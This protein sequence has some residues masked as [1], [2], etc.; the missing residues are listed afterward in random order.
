MDVPAFLEQLKSAPWYRQQ[1][2]HVEMIPPRGANLGSLNDPL[3]PALQSILEG[4]EMW[5][6]YLHQTDAI[7]GLRSGQNVVVAT[8][9]ASGK[10]LCYHLPVI[11]TIL[12]DR[13]A[14]ALYIYPSKALAQDQL[15]S[16]KDLGEG[17]PVQAAIFDGDTPGQVRAGIKRSAQI[18]L[19]NPDMLHLGI[20]PN[21][22]TWSRL[23]RSLRYVVLD[24]A[25]IYRGVFGSHM[26]NVVRRLR[27]LCTEYGSSPQFILCSA[28]IANPGE[29]AQQLTGLPFLVVDED[30]APYGGK[31]FAFWNPPLL[32][33]NPAFGSA[34]GESLG[35]PAAGVKF[36]GSLKPA[37]RSANTEAASLL[38][39]LVS[40]D[41]RTL[42]F[43]RTR[44]VAELVYMYARDQLNE[45]Q[46]PL[47]NRISPYRASYMAD[48]RR[49]IEKAL[50][51]GE[52]TGVAATNALE[53]GI[54]VR[55][56]D[57]TV[58]T[59]Y[60]GS[61][62][63]TWQQS[64][65]SGRRGEESLSVFIARDNPLDQYFMNHPQTFFGRPVERALLAPDNP[66]IMQPHLL[67]A[68]YESPLSGHDS[69]LFGPN[70]IEYL[71]GLL[72]RGFL[73]YAQGKWHIDPSV[74]Y[75]AEMV[76][77]RSTSPHNYVVVQGESGV[78]LETVEEASAMLQLH[79]GAVYLHRGESYLVEHLDLDSRTATVGPND[80]TYYTQA[81]DITD[82]TVS[83][84]RASKVTGGVGVWLGDVEVVNQ[85]IGFKKRLPMTEE[86]VGDEPLDLPPRRFN[87]V[88][89]W[90]DVPQGITDRC[91]GARLDLAGGLHATEHAAIGVLPLFAL[92]DRN[93][94]GGVSTP[95]HPDTGKP[96][97]F[98]Y[99][100][101][102]GGIGIAEQGFR[103]I[104]DLWE[105]TLS[106][107]SECPCDSGCPSCIQSPKCGD[108]NHPLDK[109][110]AEELLKALCGDG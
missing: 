39:E 58:I 20:L 74:S 30:G 52:L 45:L 26:A 51:D 27:R 90:F 56:L 4:K 19:T 68:A 38:T 108:N 2:S 43:V 59:G 102:P 76:G 40:R 75:P 49:A 25:H 44:R 71:E 31:Q 12:S 9:A 79:P 89:L 60:P 106:V 32:D 55:D 85:T 7:D 64:G 16:L 61:I 73:R 15:K 80:G 84:I 109:F 96:Q 24:E 18:L 54:D 110:V 72:E 11:D 99:D 53:L 21:H 66:Y 107:I 36:P 77:I 28:T 83:K 6:L 67:C 1:L 78:I 10:S 50:F 70:L 14:R 8:P 88:A 3:N 62:A 47:G 22:R 23:L 91:R 95:L 94:I 98:I 65:R 34:K 46:P 42:T 5:P 57:A 93:D 37:R 81:R 101:H 35:G 87:T 86:V 63:S 104:D 100:G 13:S 92:C 97:I 41:I 33:T 69:D 17:L 105:A 29:L 103:M 48:D 82:I